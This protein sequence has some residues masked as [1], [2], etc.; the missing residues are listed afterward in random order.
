VPDISGD[1]PVNPRVS[2]IV[3]NWNGQALLHDCLESLAR[4]TYSEH[5]IIF[6]DNGS[7]DD[8]VYWVQ[9]NFPQVKL[10]QLPTNEGFTGG[11]LAGLETARGEFI[12]LINNDTQ[13]DA[14]WL[15]ELIKPMLRDSSV[16]ICA[17]KLLL[18]DTARINSAGIGLTTAAVGFDRGLGDKESLYGAPEHVFGACGAAVIYRRAMLKGIGFLDN[19]FFLYGEDVDLSF[20]AQ[21]AGWKCA[22]VPSAI[23]YHKLNATARKLSDLHVYYHTRNLEFVWLK[24]MPTGLIIRYAHH[25]IF[26]ELGAFC[27]LCLR[28]GKWKPFFRAKRDALKML[29]LMLRKRQAIQRRRRVSNAYLN[30]LLTSVFDKKWIRRKVSQFVRG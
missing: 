29:P 12:A 20:R 10:V 9:K 2:I 17:G 1:K 4:Q 18:N 11:N 24:N 26:Q 15:D 8:S 25:K 3:V 30:S 14:R 23:V 28:H 7:S 16:G 6:V 21:I 22:Y 19:D 13:A 5:E 27:Y